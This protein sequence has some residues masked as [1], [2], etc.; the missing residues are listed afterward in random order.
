MERECKC[1]RASER[2][3]EI[4]SLLGGEAGVDVDGEKSLNQILRRRRYVTATPQS[5]Y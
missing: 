1:E 2:A 3:S 5:V 4:E